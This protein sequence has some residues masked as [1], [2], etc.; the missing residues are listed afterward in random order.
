M[1]ATKYLQDVKSDRRDEQGCIEG[2]KGA[3]DTS[4]KFFFNAYGVSLEKS[5]SKSQPRGHQ[6]LMLNFY[7]GIVQTDMRSGRYPH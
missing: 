7:P 3:M 4:S 1:L 6:I 5:L 2:R